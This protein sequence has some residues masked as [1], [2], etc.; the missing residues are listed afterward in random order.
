MGV[1]GARPIRLGTS[2]GMGGATANMVTGYPIP[3]D[4]R[5]A[6]RRT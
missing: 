1:I 3:C 2:N 5:R 4:D 6:G